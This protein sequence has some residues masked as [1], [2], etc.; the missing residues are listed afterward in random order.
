M[1]S[2]FPKRLAALNEAGRLAIA[3][4]LLEGRVTNQRLQE[5]TEQH[6]RDLTSLLKS[7][8]DDG[9][10]V[11]DERRRWTS[12]SAAPRNNVDVTPLVPEETVPQHGDEGSQHTD[13]YSQ[14]ANPSSQHTDPSSQHTDPYPQHSGI[15]KQSPSIV[16]EV[17]NSKRISPEKVE[18][19]ILE[20]CSSDFHSAE[21]LGQAL[22]RN[23]L[24]IKN[25]YISRMVRGGRLAQKY[26]ERPNHPRQTYF[27]V[28][29]KE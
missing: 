11:A 22:L 8:V 4:A 28:R 26:P 10:L 25:H 18:A 20:I 13:P 27:T 19:A 17:R 3:T 16:L 24:T 29:R 9:F 15:G 14:H 12:Y 1:Q 23:P 7:L 2:L 5:L 21:M 6:P